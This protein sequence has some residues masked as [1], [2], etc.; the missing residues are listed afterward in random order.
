MGF[1]PGNKNVISEANLAEVHPAHFM[2]VF[3]HF[4]DHTERAGVVF[5]PAGSQIFVIPS[6]VLALTRSWLSQA[7]TFLGHSAGI[8]FATRA[9]VG[10][11]PRLFG[12]LHS[13]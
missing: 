2:V 5:V 1:I 11:E 6:R 10:E 7:L 4:P 3:I 9:L 12:K 13:Q 8:A